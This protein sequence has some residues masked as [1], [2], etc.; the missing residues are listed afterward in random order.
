MNNVK[1]ILKKLKII[2]LEF[3]YN[4]KKHYSSRYVR[5]Y[6]DLILSFII[7]GCSTSDYYRY[8]FYEKSGYA[9]SKYITY[10]RSQYLIYKCNNKNYVPIFKNKASFNEKYYKYINR[11]WLLI[12]KSSYSEFR[13][14]ILKHKS[15]IFKPVD[16]GSGRDIFIYNYKSN[17]SLKEYYINYNTFIMEEVLSQHESLK[18]LNP[19]SVNTV[20]VLTAIPKNGN[21]PL[22][23]ACSLKTG[24][25][26]SCVDNLHANGVV[27][28]VD[29]ETGMVNGL[30]VDRN[31]KRY[32]H[33]PVT[34]EK[35]IG[36]DVPN[37][38]LLKNKITEIAS[39]VPEMRYVG[40]DIA[41]LKNDI[42]LIEG[43][44]RPAPEL[45][46]LIEQKGHWLKFKYEIL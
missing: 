19:N 39:I 41:I 13:E 10:R 46:Q 24:G 7:Y 36:F 26:T 45:T 43:N 2:I 42:A 29:I 5:A 17:D 23:I 14:F 16:G 11:E 34:N 27:G 21:K 20:R 33:H 3:N 44:T 38:E 35:M 4:T 12:S 9:K 25:E 1:K 37:W 22:I 31:F 32:S 40:W 15:V 8:K 6:I 30:C 28:N 18:K